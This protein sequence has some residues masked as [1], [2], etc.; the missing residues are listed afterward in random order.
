MSNPKQREER[1]MQFLKRIS[2]PKPTTRQKFKKLADNLNI[3]LIK[4]SEEFVHDT[5]VSI[6]NK[7][8]LK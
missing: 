2:N 7:K 5:T 8:V 1:T 3:K 6:A 4:E